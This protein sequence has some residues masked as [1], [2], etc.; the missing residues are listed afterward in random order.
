VLLQAWKIQEQ[1][2]KAFLADA[3]AIVDYFNLELMIVEPF[4]QGREL[5]GY[6]L[7]L[8]QL[9]WGFLACFCEPLGSELDFNLPF[10]RCEF[11]SIWDEVDE[12]LLESVLVSVY[13]GEQMLMVVLYIH[14]CGYCLLL[15]NKFESVEGWLDSLHQVEERLVQ[16][17]GQS[18]LLCQIEQVVY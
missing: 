2:S 10:L 16:L 1:F 7:P 4:R 14:F 18:L 8:L 13:F 5:A 17:E 9:L 11:E 6:F 12:Y 3:V 15:R